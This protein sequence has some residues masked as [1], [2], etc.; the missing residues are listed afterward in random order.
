FKIFTQL[1]GSMSRSEGGLG[2]GLSLVASL[3]KMHGGT[4]QAFSGGIGQG[5]EFIVR[6]PLL[7]EAFQPTLATERNGENRR[8]P[9][10]RVLV[11]DDNKDAAESLAVL[12]RL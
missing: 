10:R 9:P 3:V 8:L 2:I 6:L 7:Q 11:V 12:L 4:V 5:S 1:P